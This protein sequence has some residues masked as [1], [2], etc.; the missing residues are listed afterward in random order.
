[1]ANKHTKRCSISLLIRQIQIKTTTRFYFTPTRLVIII[2][3]KI[4]V[5]V[6]I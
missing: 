1:M 5:L 3:E 4:N 6:R 2:I